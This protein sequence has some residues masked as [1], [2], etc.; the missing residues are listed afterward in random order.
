MKKGTIYCI[1][2]KI[3]GK[4]YVGQTI[5]DLAVRFNEH[6]FDDRSNSK[7]HQAIKKYGWQ[8]FKC[9]VLEELEPEELD[10]RERYYIKEWN[11]QDDKYGYNILSGGQIEKPSKK[12][13]VVENG[14][15]FNNIE[16]A[17]RII[18]DITKWWTFGTTVKKLREITNTDKTLCNYHFKQIDCLTEPSPID[19]LEDW[20]KGLTVRYAGKHIYCVE[21]DKNFETIAEG[22][23][24]LLDNNLYETTSKTPIQSLVTAIGKNINGKTE[25]I[26]GKETEFHFWTVPGTI[27]QVGSSNPFETKKVYC[28]Q[29]DKEFNSQ[30][31]CAK[32]FID[33]NIWTG[34]KLKTARLRISDVVRGYFSDYRGYTFERR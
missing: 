16:S 31:E 14:L 18:S 13:L 17:A 26:K 22:A 1:T 30:I 4:K 2:N 34:I 28:P 20:I 6:C 32:Y 23:K 19:Q 27:K 10:E 8:N 11:L 33:N 21:L 29:I 9:E 7:I 5:R 15:I 25:S 12:L 24:Y 3:N